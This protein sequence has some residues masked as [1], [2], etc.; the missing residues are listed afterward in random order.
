MEVKQQIN[1]T[2]YTRLSE[3]NELDSHEN[4]IIE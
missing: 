2:L 1:Q 4:I 3:V